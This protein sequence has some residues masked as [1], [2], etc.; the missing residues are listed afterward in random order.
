MPDRSRSTPTCRLRTV[1][2]LGGT[3]K[4]CGAPW[5]ARKE[6]SMN[7]DFAWF[8]VKLALALFGGCDCPP[9]L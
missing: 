1:I 6:K 5:Q 7:W 8:L 2:R 3:P 9:L 4:P